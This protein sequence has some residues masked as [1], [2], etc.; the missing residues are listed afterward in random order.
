MVKSMTVQPPRTLMRT[1][2][3]K[4]CPFVHQK[5]GASRNFSAE[6]CVFKYSVKNANDTKRFPGP[7]P[8]ITGFLSVRPSYRP[9]GKFSGAHRYLKGGQRKRWKDR[10]R[11]ITNRMLE[12]DNPS[13][14]SFGRLAFGRLAFYPEFPGSRWAGQ[15]RQLSGAFDPG[16][17]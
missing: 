3:I 5:K 12:T 6:P 4:C 8:G 16:H 17:S 7:Y 14:P 10:Q 9:P 15:H 11:P 1:E 13:L 2:S